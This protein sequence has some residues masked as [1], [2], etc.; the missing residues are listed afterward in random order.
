MTTQQPKS[1]SLGLACAIAALTLAAS[2]GCPA[3][4]AVAPPSQPATASSPI[5]ASLASSAPAASAASSLASS[6]TT[7]NATAASSA[8][9]SPPS[10]QASTIEDCAAEKAIAPS[11]TADEVT[12]AVRKLTSLCGQVSLG[13][14]S[15]C[16]VRMPTSDELLSDVTQCAAT[17]HATTVSFRVDFGD[18]QHFS[19]TPS[20]AECAPVCDVTIRSAEWQG[21]RFIAVQQSVAGWI[22]WV[23]ATD[24]YEILHGEAVPYFRG[25]PGDCP[26][27]GHG[28]GRR[29][30]TGGF[31]DAAF[32]SSAFKVDYPRIPWEVVNVVCGYEPQD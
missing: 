7:A 22:P 28:E 15:D 27:A 18:Q 13:A 30:I 16:N 5:A 14:V 24:A 20:G 3:S 12:A 21:R 31:G 2:A 32:R 23:G 11:T 8:P 17:A 4:P 6:S 25:A 9:R 10:P 19:L 26:V 29:A 1:F